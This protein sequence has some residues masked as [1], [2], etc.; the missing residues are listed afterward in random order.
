[1]KLRMIAAMAIGLIRLLPPSSA[2]ADNVVLEP[3]DRC[4]NLFADSDTQLLYRLQPT[5]PLK[6]R[7]RWSLSV[8]QRTI[9]HG[10]AAVNAAAGKT[11]VFAFPLR[12]PH[13]KEGVVL[14]ALCSVA[15]YAD[16][17]Q[18]QETLAA[19]DKTLWIFPRD[20]FVDR[21]V[22]LKG[23]KITLFDPE[24]KTADVLEKAGFPF[25]LSRNIDALDG[26][27]QGL[28]MIGEA[29]AWRDHHSL[30]E[31]MVK[32]AARGLPVLCL[33]PGEGSIQLPG[34]EG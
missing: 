29:T 21:R 12:T 3:A 5:A 4:S 22:W 10:E 25:T 13:V 6:G 14:Q 24:G 16:G 31:V 7:I 1:M 26:V 18:R 20:P 33:A 30:G 2:T 19:H 9:A 11:I 17:E 23:L 28:L 8:H 34:A 15:V 27:E 32:A